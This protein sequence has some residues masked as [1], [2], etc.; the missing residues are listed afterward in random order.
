MTALVN[1]PSSSPA[2]LSEPPGANYAFTSPQS[3]T[4]VLATAK[5]LE[6]LAARLQA[7]APAAELSILSAYQVAQPAQAGQAAPVTNDGLGLALTL[8]LSSPITGLDL[9][10]SGLT[11]D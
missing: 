9:S 7:V 4:M 8:V 6:R 5:A 1:L 11:C 10:T 3:N 2:L